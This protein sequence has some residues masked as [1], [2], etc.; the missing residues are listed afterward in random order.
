ML[1]RGLTKLREK[2]ANCSHGKKK[3]NYRKDS[4]FTV[5]KIFKVEEKGNFG[6]ITPSIHQISSNE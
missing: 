5:T 2:H 4:I 6:D 3:K 1:K